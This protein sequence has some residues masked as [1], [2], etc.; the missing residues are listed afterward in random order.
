M[1]TNAYSE[2]KG[3]GGSSAGSAAAGPKL[4]SGAHYA[5]WR[6]DMEV[7]LERHGAH[8]VH[9]RVIDAKRWKAAQSTVQAL[10]EA[11]LTAALDAMLGAATAGLQSTKQLAAVATPPPAVPSGY[12]P[13]AEKLLRDMVERST[14]VYGTLY[15]ALPEELR[16]QAE[17]I[18]RGWAY[19]LWQ[20]LQTKFQS[21][22]SDNVSTM[23][24]EWVTLQQDAD[25][26][27]DSYRARVDKLDTLLAAAKE[28]QSRRMY[29]V[30]LLDRLQPHYKQAVLAL[31]VSGRLADPANAAWDTIAALIN[32]HEREETRTGS[33]GVAAVARGAWANA[34]QT[35]ARYGQERQAE[36]R[37]YPAATADTQCFRCR[38][39]G[40]YSKTCS[41][42]RV[43]D[44]TFNKNVS[45]EKPRGGGK[46]HIKSALKQTKAVA[47]A[48]AAGNRFDSLTD[49]SEDGL[50]A[51]G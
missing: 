36:R 12:T 45:F 19:G 27:F 31:K 46:A 11:K 41:K 44:A 22:E 25:E 51:V 20:W 30:I 24:A 23:L 47:P 43:D 39:Y 42:P 33:E 9:T 21:T 18:P 7:Y 49:D 38:E 48:A 14:R 15:A 1:S 3:A 37:E 34:A 16:K 2:D 35:K 26:S 17:S 5:Q 6:P 10:D 4:R 8:G 40:H 32:N 29:S 28:P 50:G 13:E